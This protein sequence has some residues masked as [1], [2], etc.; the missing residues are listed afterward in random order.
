MR[1]IIIVWLS[2]LI[3]VVSAHPV[4]TGTFHK[5]PPGLGW[6]LTYEALMKDNA[7]HDGDWVSRW[8]REHKR[9]PIKEVLSHWDRGQIVSSVLIDHPAFHAGERIGFWLVRTERYAFV[10]LCT[11]GKLEEQ[12]ESTQVDVSLYDSLLAEVQRWEQ[13][14]PLQE[15]DAPPGAP[16]GYFAFLNIY[17][18]SASRQ[19]LLTFRDF[20]EPQDNDWDSA[21]NGRVLGLLAPI[22]SGLR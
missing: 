10:L 14:A 21:S 7:V 11:D 12:T 18:G 8:V 13:R 6:D 15:D 20:F 5:A 2:A 19:M 22:L 1:K 16:G 9:P 3:V 17:D 4:A